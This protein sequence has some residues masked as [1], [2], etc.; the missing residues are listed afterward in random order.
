M[1]TDQMASMSIIEDF[2]TTSEEQQI[3]EAIRQ[4][5]LN[6]SGEIRVHIENCCSQGAEARA[7]E[8]FSILKMDNTKLQ[9]AVL[10]Y[11]AVHDHHFAIYGDNGINNVVPDSFWNTTKDII[12]DHFRKGEFGIGLINGIACVGEQLKLYF[13]WNSDDSNELPNTI[14]TS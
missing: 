8:V 1:T 10:I 11:I 3:I 4:A 2:L 5:E 13:P 9:N 12:Q 6:T 14:S 7:K